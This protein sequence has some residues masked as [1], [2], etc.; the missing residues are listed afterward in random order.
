MAVRT[1]LFAL[2][3]QG[4]GGFGTSQVW[5]A[6]GLALAGLPITAALTLGLEIQVLDLLVALPEGCVGWVALRVRRHLAGGAADPAASTP[7]GVVV[8]SGDQA[9]SSD[10]SEPRR[11]LMGAPGGRGA[12]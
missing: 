11:E 5:W 3:V 7:A 10:G 9:M 1:L 2:P 4:L 12:R 8:A 6:G